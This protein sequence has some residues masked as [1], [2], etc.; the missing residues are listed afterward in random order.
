MSDLIGLIAISFF[1]L[2]GGFL[3][4]YVVGKANDVGPQIA[5]GV[6]RGS[7][8][9]VGVREGLLFGIWLPCEAAAVATTAFVGL[10]ELEMADHVSSEG[11]KLLAYFAAFINVMG[12][13]LIL[14]GAS[15]AFFRYRAKLRRVRQRQAEAD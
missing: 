15:F 5:T 12:A 6:V 4:I 7:P 1:T 3:T 11:V 9:S 13:L 14:T 2:S 8:V 10:A